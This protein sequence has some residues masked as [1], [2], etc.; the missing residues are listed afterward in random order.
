VNRRNFLL[1]LLFVLPLP[2]LLAEGSPAS[3]GGTFTFSVKDENVLNNSYIETDKGPAFDSEITLNTIFQELIKDETLE[4]GL[5]FNIDD[6]LNLTDAKSRDSSPDGT[7]NNGYDKIQKMIDWYINNR[8]R[9]GMSDY[10]DAFT[11]TGWPTTF[12]GGT[13]GYQFIVGNT[14]EDINSVIWTSDKW[15]DAYRLFDDIKTEVLDEIEKIS[16]Y[17]LDSD[18]N[19]SQFEIDGMTV[20][21]KQLLLDEM[22][23]YRSFREAYLGTS[24]SAALGDL[25]SD[26]YI[27]FNNLF[28][29]MRVSLEYNG[30]DIETGRAIK[31]SRASQGDSMLGIEVALDLDEDILPNLS[32]SL[33]TV[34]TEG[35]AK[36]AEDWAEKSYDYD[37]GEY[38]D[39]GFLLNGSYDIKGLGSLEIEGGILDISCPGNFV[40]GIYPTLDIW[41]FYK[42][43]VAGEFDMLGHRNEDD[44]ND[45][46]KIGLAAALDMEMSFFGVTP[47]V[48]LLWKNNQYFG[49]TLSN[50]AEDRLPGT[51]LMNDFNSSNVKMSAALDAGLSFSTEKLNGRELVSVG[52]GYNLFIY[53]PLVSTRLLRHGWYGELNVSLKDYLEVPLSVDFSMSRYN[54]AEQIIFDD[55]EGTGPAAGF[56]DGLSWGVNI[57]YVLNDN[58]T[59]SGSCTGSDTGYRL[60]TSQILTW[61]LS[62]RTSF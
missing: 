10:P 54:P 21:E 49:T 55:Y 29:F 62:A 59:F 4:I 18:G 48:K 43:K 26:A 19:Y 32:A 23:A 3:L 27:R 46:L 36:T 22:E 1:Y 53:D 5:T 2:A 45:T 16:P 20:A 58:V 24:S 33:L 56:A 38:G 14:A 35:E 17:V 13:A 9:Y 44:P 25:V 47:R 42:L 30:R 7:D 61:E 28:N 60:D 15:D 52:G 41:H 12:Y 50:L 37:S 40:L 51:S 6:A 8:S 39:F 11:G 34:L 57:E 31:S